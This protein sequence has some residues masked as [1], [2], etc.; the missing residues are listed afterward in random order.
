[1]K[2]QNVRPIW[3]IASDIQKDWKN[4]NYAA[5]PYLEAMAG[6]ESIQDTFGY[7]NGQGIVLYFLGNARAWKGEKAKEIKKEL[8][9]MLK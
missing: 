3:A 1:M 5:K 4:V 2:T 8:K 9:G 6:L 7:D